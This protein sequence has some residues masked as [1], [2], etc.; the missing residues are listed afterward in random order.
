MAAD[1]CTFA[2][3][4]L[5]ARSL[6][7]GGPNLRD[8]N[9]SATLTVKTT[10]PYIRGIAY[11]LAQVRDSFDTGT[12]PL[13]TYRVQGDGSYITEDNGANPQPYTIAVPNSILVEY[14]LGVQYRY[15][16]VVTYDRFASADWNPDYYQQEALGYKRRFQMPTWTAWSYFAPVS[17]LN[18]WVFDAR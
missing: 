1:T 7:N 16:Y 4:S 18:A 8:Y 17:G 3:P 10:T 5:V 6:E 15:M 14:Q 12:A 2:E 9:F 13:A 11:V